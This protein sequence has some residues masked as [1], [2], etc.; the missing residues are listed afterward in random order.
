MKAR[1]D[2]AFVL[3]SVLDFEKR[4]TVERVL[5]TLLSAPLPLRP[6]HYGHSEADQRISDLKDVAD[7][8]V[9]VHRSATQSERFGG[10]LLRSGRCRYQLQ[11]S[12]MRKPSMPFLLGSVDRE[13]IES[14]P[15]Q[16]SALYD[17]IKKL[18][19]EVTAVYGEIRDMS[20]PFSDMPIDLWKR[21]PDLPAV[22]IYGFP[23]L[24]MF[25]ETRLRDAPFCYMEQLSGGQYWLQ[26][27][28]TL[29]EPVSEQTK[30]AIR[31]HLGEDAFMSDGKR[32]YKTGLAP[33]FDTSHLRP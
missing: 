27:S 9:G 12:K 20:S 16:V 23:Y 30:A 7:L 4:D 2:I 6:T 8:I 33:E 15:A 18:V 28:G 26:A 3:Y 14:S 5:E 29:L 10:V 31:S 21:L 24:T 13:L 17:L 11:W 25:G 19:F 1:N 22:S 32:L